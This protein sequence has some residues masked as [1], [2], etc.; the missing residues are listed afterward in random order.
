MLRAANDIETD[1]AFA[2]S[3]H[4]HLETPVRMTYA[5]EGSSMP[6]LTR[7]MPALSLQDMEGVTML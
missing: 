2:L 5:D 4:R 7:S 3:T 6:R 1:A